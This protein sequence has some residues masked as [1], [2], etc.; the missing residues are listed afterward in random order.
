MREKQ[1]ESRRDGF[2]LA[3]VMRLACQALNKILTS[4]QRTETTQLIKKYPLGCFYPLENFYAARRAQ[5]YAIALE[6]YHSRADSRSFAVF[7]FSDTHFFIFNLAAKFVSCAREEGVGGLILCQWHDTEAAPDQTRSFLMSQPYEVRLII[8]RNEH[9]YLA[10]LVEPHNQESDQFTLGLPVG[11]A[12]A[13]DLRWYLEK[14][15]QL[16]GAGDH[17]RARGIEARLNDWGKA[18]FDEIFDTSQGT[19][20][21][22]NLLEAVKSSSNSGNNCLLTLGSTDPEVLLQPWEMM[23]D[24]RGPLAFQGIT[25]RRQLRGAGKPPA[26]ELRLPL[27]VL[28]IVS[29]PEDIGFIDPRNSIAPLLEALQALPGGQVQVD[30][31]DP[32]TLP[33][34]ERTISAARKVK[35]PYHLVHFDGHGTYLPKTG[36]GALAFEKDDYTADLVTGTQMGDLLARLEVPLVLLEACRSSDLSNRPVFGSVAP[37]LLQS[38]VG[39]VIAFSHSVHIQA[40]K[41]LVERF[42]RELVAGMTIGQAVEEARAAMHADR[43]RW[44]HLGPNAESI[45]LQ[46]W[47]IPQLYQV[48]ADLSLL[49]SRKSSARPKS[50]AQPFASRPLPGFPPAPMY[51]FHGRAMELLEL[52]RIFRRHSAVVVAG[53][54]GM[55]KTALARE[56]AGWWLRTQRFES[57]VFCSFE[58]KAGAERVVQLLGQ[59]LEGDDFSSR[60]GENQWRTAVDLFHRRKVLL[61]WDNF[62]STLPAFQDT[63]GASRWDAQTTNV[64]A[65][66]RDAPTEFGEEARNRLL[67]LYRELTEGAP[68]GKILVT[69]RP[70]ETGLPGI[71]EFSLTGLARPDSLHLLA[72]VLDLKDIKLDRP[73]Y[74]RHEIEALLEALDDHPLSI[75]LVAPHL[76]EL[77]P[78][79]IRQEFGQLLEKFSHESAAEGRNRSLQASLAFSCK[80]LSQAAQQM[81]PYLAWFEGGVFEQFLLDFSGQQPATWNKIRN[82]LVAT[83]L[84]KIEDLPQFKIPFLRFH[85]TLSYAAKAG[86]VPHPEATEQKFIEVYLGVRGA[87]YQMLRGSQPAVGMALMAAEEANLRRAMTLAF[88]RGERLQGA[89]IADTLRDYLERAQRLRERDALVAWV[90]QQMPE[91]AG[92]D[93]ATC[94]AIRQHAWSQ[95]TQ[96]HAQEALDMV[97]NLINRLESEGLAGPVGSSSSSR[98]DLAQ[99]ELSN[100]AGGEEVTFQVAVSKLY[101]GRIYNHAGRSDLAVQPLQQAIAGFEQLGEP[102]RGNLAAALGD[103]ANAY[104]RLGQFDAALQAAERSLQINREMGRS[105]E[106]ATGLGQI[107]QILMQQQRYSEAEGRY[108]EALQSAREAGDLELQGSLLQH[109][110]GLQDVRGHYDRAVDLYK[111]AL[112]LFQ[113]ANAQA[114]EMRTCDLLAT[115]ER[116]RGQLQAAEAWY[117]R[118][119]ELAQQL[120]DQRQLAV[121]AQNLGILYQKR[122]EQT[123]NPAEREA[124]LR[125]AVGSVQSGLEINLERQDQVEAARSYFQLGVLHWMLN[126]LDQAENNALNALKIRETLNLPDVYKDYINLANIARDR[127]DQQAAAQWQAKYEAKWAEVQKLRRGQ[128]GAGGKG[129]MPEEL[130]KGIIGLAQAVYAA[131]MS[132]SPLPA[133]V[134]E[135]L[136]QLAE[137]PAPFNSLS[138]FLQAIGNGKPVPAIPPGLPPQIQQVLAAL[139]GAIK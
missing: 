91:D 89:W 130:L 51:R 104:G 38:G 60:S 116:Q 132:Q 133:E 131:R 67:Q 62:E 98:I 68:L 64:R 123:T 75:E 126:E 74:E 4:F 139:V 128:Q 65:S 6:N 45:E 77:P 43:R 69:C 22:R 90:R 122:A 47:F 61:V 118:A 40:A 54:G 48:G 42:Y 8:D 124:L 100:G 18:L 21:Y 76:K 17:A 103:L 112:A 96:G 97:Q 19:H 84:I 10:R 14:Y 12:E 1:G 52:E 81:L 27:R 58:Q 115:A 73:G 80:R 53:M 13:A 101:L 66:R 7:A 39:S 49:T 15:L 87:A 24:S 120:G 11:E 92:L 117:H 55:G 108:E 20:V 114:S 135:V 85:P 25:I 83:A 63:V 93:E 36:I 31:C 30:F 113:R 71:K 16:P 129:Q 59:A 9:G 102:Q 44:L 57:A 105:R 137:T 127:G 125:Q 2:Y 95:F 33:Q 138:G 37:A 41:I 119:R 29:R 35:Q 134:N 136:A 99:K 78:A 26:H 34:L 86:E 70:V 3:M 110:A 111:Q 107:A 23:R 32:P 79:T 46:D 106:I 5:V 121:V 50:E 109:M 72:A 28:L 88:R 56:A 94:E 82:E